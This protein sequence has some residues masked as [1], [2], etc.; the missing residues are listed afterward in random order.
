MVSNQGKIGNAL[1]KST[2]VDV[3]NSEQLVCGCDNMFN[4]GYVASSVTSAKVSI[5]NS[6]SFGYLW[7]L[8]FSSFF[9]GDVTSMYS[10][11]MRIWLQ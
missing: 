4:A 8:F 11:S 3:P 10:I 9:D 6:V 1:K 7:K 2:E 5:S